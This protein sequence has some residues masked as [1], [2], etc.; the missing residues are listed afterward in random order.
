MGG[1]FGKTEFVYGNGEGESFFGT[2]NKNSVTES[3]GFEEEYFV[4]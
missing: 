1:Y 3:F 4:P 2:E